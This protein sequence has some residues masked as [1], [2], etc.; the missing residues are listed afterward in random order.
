[1]YTEY[2]NQNISPDNIPGSSLNGNFNNEFDDDSKIR[3]LFGIVWKILLVLVILVMLFIGLVQFGVI[4]FNSGVS[5]EVVILNQ[6]EIGIKKGAGYQLV[7]TVLPENSSNKQVIW[8][9][10]N[11]DVVSVN[12]ATGYV[13]AVKEGTAVI[14]VRTLINDQISE[15]VVN[16]GN[17]NVLVNSISINEKYINL[18][19]GYNQT[20]SYSLSPSNATENSLK[21]T[22]SDTSVATV[23]S[24]GVVKGIKEGSAIIT[25]TSSNGEVRDTAYVTV[26]K[27][28]EATVVEGQPVKTVSYPSSIT[29]SDKSVNLTAGSKSQLVASI[30]PSDANNYISW[31]S[32]NSKIASVDSNGLI[33]AKEAGTA[34]IVAKTINGL[35]ASCTVTVGNYSLKLKGVKITTEYSVL[36]IGSSK[37]VVAVFEPSNASNKSVT[38][39]SSNTKVATINGSGLIKAVG[40]GNATITVKS[41][42]GGFT[43]TLIIE[44]ANPTNIIEEK[45]ISFASST[46]SIAVNGTVTLNPTITPSNATFKTVSFTSSDPSIATVDANGVVKGLKKGKVTIT[47]ITNRNQVKAS[48]TVNVNEVFVT[49]A[50]LNTTSIE[51]NKGSTYTLVSDILPSNA[52]NKK[53]TWSSSDNNIATVD[54]NGIVT[55]KS[56]GT[57]TITVK[58]SD[59]SKTATSVVKVK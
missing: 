8:E 3:K 32:S 49:S 41:A 22:S 24:K 42:D 9:S 19:V 4:S 11:P 18:A 46:Y 39:S 25:V 37:Q 44:V 1:M 21:F 52:T 54:A 59:G 2:N 35:T 27:K 58:T 15:C 48:V 23:N 56:T 31:S 47:A 45:G 10:S 5:P 40:V 28:G 51:I 26:Y 14:T 17:V 53:V 30:N 43:D 12:E 50:K 33:T 13:K 29:L 57:V 34:T 20:L 36:P 55:G 16:V 6:N 7:T 38:W